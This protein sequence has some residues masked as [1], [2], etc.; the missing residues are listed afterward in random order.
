MAL[1]IAKELLRNP[2]PYLRNSE[3]VVFGFGIHAKEFFT[4]I[5]GP[6][7][8]K[9]FGFIEHD[10]LL[11]LLSKASV[12]IYT[13]KGEGMPTLVL[14]ALAMGTPTIVPYVQGCVDLA[15]MYGLPVYRSYREAVVLAKRILEDREYYRRKF[16]LIRE[17]VLNVHH[18]VAIAKSFLQLYSASDD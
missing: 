8:V 6:V 10:A 13:S 17:R 2:M 12:F 11:E 9:V 14:E 18:P 5:K 15:K 4:G 7:N 1:F 16:N 3:L